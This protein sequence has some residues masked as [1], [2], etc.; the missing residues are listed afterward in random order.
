M[1]ADGNSELTGIWENGH[2]AGLKNALIPDQS[3]LQSAL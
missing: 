1:F 3:H 2:H